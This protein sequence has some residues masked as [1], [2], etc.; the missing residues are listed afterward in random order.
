M[1]DLIREISMD[2]KAAYGFADV[3]NALVTVQ[4]KPC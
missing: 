1:E 3:K 2:G 4:L